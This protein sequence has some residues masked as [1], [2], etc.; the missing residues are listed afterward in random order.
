MVLHPLE[1]T[2]GKAARC[3]RGSRR[4]FARVPRLGLGIVMR[5]RRGKEATKCD[6]ISMDL[7]ASLTPDSC[8]HGGMIELEEAEFG[9]RSGPGA[10]GA[11]SKVYKG[12]AKRKTW[13][14]LTGSGT[15]LFRPQGVGGLRSH[16][17]RV[18][19]RHGQAVIT[20][21]L[22]MV[23]AARSRI[24]RAGE[25][26]HTAPNHRQEIRSASNDDN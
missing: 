5:D 14:G 18:S 2:I 16:F 13:R 20:L 11:P 15:G 19:M 22:R 1:E 24:D 21:P 4:D 3:L 7:P 12:Y 9:R 25:S 23:D 6:M 8:R 10:V 17:P 26:A